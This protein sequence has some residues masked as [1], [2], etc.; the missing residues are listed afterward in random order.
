MRDRF[1]NKK[2]TPV[3]KKSQQESPWQI[4]FHWLWNDK[5]PR[6]SQDYIWDSWKNR[7]ENSKD[8]IQFS[9]RFTEYGAKV[10]VI[11]AP[12]PRETLSVNTPLNF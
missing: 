2:G 7:A 10:M 6:R 9:D 3:R 1:G 8:W 4:I 12:Q 5:Y 11:P